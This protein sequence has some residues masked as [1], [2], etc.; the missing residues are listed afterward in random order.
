[1]VKT[2]QRFSLVL[3][4]K[5][6]DIH[7]TSPFKESY[8]ITNGWLNPLLDRIGLWR[9]LERGMSMI[10]KND[11]SGIAAVHHTNVDETKPPHMT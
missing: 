3:T 5:V 8:C 7:H 1:M 2:L 4:P 10:T 9:I 6:H 11:Y